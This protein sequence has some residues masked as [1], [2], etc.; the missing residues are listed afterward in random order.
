MSFDANIFFGATGFVFGVVGTFIAVEEYLK[1]GKLKKIID[2]IKNEGF[3]QN[4]KKG[5]DMLPN[6]S[7]LEL[8]EVAQQLSSKYLIPYLNASNTGDQNNV[9]NLWEKVALDVGKTVDSNIRRSNSSAPSGL[10]EYIAFSFLSA[11]SKDRA[12]DF[13]TNVVSRHPST[14]ANF[15]RYYLSAKNN[16][17][18]I[19]DILRKFETF[20]KE[21]VEA[22][23]TG[24]KGQIPT[25]IAE[26]F[27]N[28]KW[29]QRMVERLREFVNNRNLSYNS[30]VGKLLETNPMPK[31]YFIFKNEGTEPETEDAPANGKIVLAK[32]NE[33]RSKGEINAITNMASIY[34]GKD[35][36]AIRRFL[37]SLPSGTENNYVVFV[38]EVDP[39]TMNVKTSDKLDGV[40]ER[41]YLNLQNFRDFKDIYE[42]IIVKLGLK[43]SEIIET[44]DLGF[45]LEI[46]T[47]A[48]SDALRKHSESI[49]K[50]L[51]DNIGRAIEALTDLKNLD[52]DEIGQ[53]ADILSKKCNLKPSNGREI[54]LKIVKE[55]KELY[56]SVYG[57]DRTNHA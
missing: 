52:E 42:G 57:K 49:K 35:E 32:L 25:K 51:G 15:A 22:I 55:S 11:Y 3:A 39:L 8:Q 29:N 45:L 40:P 18:S 10:S 1:N 26:L 19:A 17:R 50:E 56:D 31:L 5:L 47:T 24:L 36:T 6:I 2:G 21:E 41:M 30:I 33:M 48:L 37:E 4:I 53:F 13:L 23:L 44:A 43:P 14:E 12:Q 7:D 28:A 16:P 9:L 46:K 54:A 27:R 20:S 38:G 34:F